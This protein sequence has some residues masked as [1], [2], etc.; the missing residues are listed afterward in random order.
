L[1]NARSP[2]KGNAH[3]QSPPHQQ[4]VQP[5]AA[6]T[7]RRATRDSA[8]GGRSVIGKTQT[9][10]R[11]SYRGVQPDAEVLQRGYTFRKKTFATWLVNRRLARVHN[12]CAESLLT[13]RYRRRYPCWP[14]SDDQDFRTCGHWPPL[15]TNVT[16][17]A[18][19][20]IQDPSRPRCLTSPAPDD[21]WYKRLPEPATRTWK[22]YFPRAASKPTMPTNR[23]P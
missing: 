9:S 6:Q 18:R 2:A 20:R 15:P 16:R 12:R 10:N 4:I 13:C 1:R 3:L 14:R 17:R 19:R 11:E 21:D 5:A 22:K 7:K 23:P 8:A